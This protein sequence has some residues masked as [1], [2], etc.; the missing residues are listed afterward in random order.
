[1]EKLPGIVKSSQLS[2]ALKSYV[3]TE[4][5][6]EFYVDKTELYA[7]ASL[8]VNVG[9]S[10]DAFFVT[11]DPFDDY[12]VVAMS[13]TEVVKLMCGA[14]GC[15]QDIRVFGGSWAVAVSSYS[16][17]AQ[18]DNGA[19]LSLDDFEMKISLIGAATTWSIDLDA[20]DPAL[21]T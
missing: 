15:S 18:S 10:G 7:L 6:R 12:A 1:M 16:S 20:I 21:S 19:M 4:K 9:A 17:G 8:I 2:L 3:A 11:T 14:I 5:S 13:F